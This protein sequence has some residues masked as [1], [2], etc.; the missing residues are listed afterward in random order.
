MWPPLDDIFDICLILLLGCYSSKLC[1]SESGGV[2]NGSTD[3]L[4]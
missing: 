1:R 3:N 2:G 4:P